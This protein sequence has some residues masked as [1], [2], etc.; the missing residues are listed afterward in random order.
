MKYKIGDKVRIKSDLQVGIEYDYWPILPMMEKYLG[1]ELII[2]TV[3]TEFYQVE[4]NCFSWTDE[5]IEG[6]VED[7]KV[8]LEGEDPMPLNSHKYIRVH[9]VDKFYPKDDHFNCSNYD[10]GWQAM[11]KEQ[12]QHCKKHKPNDNKHHEDLMK[13]SIAAMQGILA[14][15][16]FYSMSNADVCKKSIELAKE[17]LTQLKLE[18]K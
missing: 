15:S 12:C 7:E 3:L 6:L 11:C 1:K 13:A 5:M 17:M 14:N 8:K 2:Q 10:T 4:G 16:Y 18:Q 9:D